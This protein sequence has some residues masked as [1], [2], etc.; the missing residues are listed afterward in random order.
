MASLRASEL[1]EV[2]RLAL[3]GSPMVSGLGPH[4]SGLA[5]GELPLVVHIC[6]CLVRVASRS[7]YGRQHSHR[8]NLNN[9][10]RCVKPA[11]SNPGIVVCS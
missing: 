5:L 9:L 1:R 11:N 4:S 10:N 6:L 2:S 3:R 7:G 8:N